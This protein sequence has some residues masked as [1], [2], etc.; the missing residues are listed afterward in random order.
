MVPFMNKYQIFPEG[1]RVSNYVSK[2]TQFSCVL[3]YTD[4][5]SRKNSMFSTGAE[6]VLKELC[7][8]QLQNGLESDKTLGHIWSSK[9]AKTMFSTINE[10]DMSGSVRCYTFSLDG[11][12]VEYSAHAS[13]ATRFRV[14]IH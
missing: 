9:S 13:L 3:V 5:S 6:K 12:H 11:E 2:G 1:R 4:P 14:L 7:K 10:V 8:S